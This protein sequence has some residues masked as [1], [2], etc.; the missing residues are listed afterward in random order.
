[1]YFTFS[2]YSFGF[3]C[4]RLSTTVPDSGICCFIFSSSSII[5]VY[6][7]AIRLTATSAAAYSK[8]SFWI[9]KPF[10][11]CFPRRRTGRASIFQASFFSPF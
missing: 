3:T 5:M 7:K 2:S 4:F 9:I 1:M 10:I 11:F 8:P 6:A